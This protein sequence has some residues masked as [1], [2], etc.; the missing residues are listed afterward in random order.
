MLVALSSD[1]ELNC[2]VHIDNG[3]FESFVC[4]LSTNICDDHSIRFKL[5]DW[6]KNFP[7][8]IHIDEHEWKDFISR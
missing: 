3:W 8:G 1:E 2:Q 6:C 5:Y 7:I 4:V